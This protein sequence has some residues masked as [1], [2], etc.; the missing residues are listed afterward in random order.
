MPARN[1][2]PLL[3]GLADPE[4]KRR[5]VGEEFIRVRD[6]ALAGAERWTPDEWLFG[7][8]DALHGYH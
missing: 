3:K 7:P 1:F 8:G 4:E 6:R 5:R 2:S